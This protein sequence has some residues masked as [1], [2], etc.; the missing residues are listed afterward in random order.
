[1]T[2]SNVINFQKHFKDRQPPEK[3]TSHYDLSKNEVDAVYKGINEFQALKTQRK[4]NAAKRQERL[5]KIFNHKDVIPLIN[6]FEETVNHSSIRT[7]RQ[8]IKNLIE[9]YVEEV[10]SAEISLT[11]AFQEFKS[12]AKNYISQLATKTTTNAQG[13]TQLTPKTKP[14]KLIHP[15]IK[16]IHEVLRNHKTLENP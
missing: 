2:D 1:M 13:N 8:I 3:R 16:G 5:H 9:N 7:D 10:I 6:A 14:L 4:A 12:Q 15:A 11:Q